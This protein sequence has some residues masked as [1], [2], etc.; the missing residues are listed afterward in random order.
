MKLGLIGLN[1]L[2]AI[3]SSQAFSAALCGGSREE[4]TTSLSCPAGQVISSVTF[5]S[6]GTPGGSCGSYTL[7]SCNASNSKNVIQAACVGKAS[8]QVRASNGIF[9]DPCS[10]IYK[11][12]LTQV[13]CAAP[14]P[15]TGWTFCANE[16]GVCNFTGTKTV[17]Y[18]ANNIFVTKTLNGPVNCSNEVFGDPVAGATKR[19]ELSNTTVG[20]PAPAPV[21]AP[22]PST[23]WTFC[24][25]EYEVCNFSGARTVRYGAN[26]IFVTKTLNGP[27][28]CSN[29]VFG[30]PVAGATKRCELSNT[31]V[32]TPAPAPAPAPPPSGSVGSTVS[33]PGLTSIPGNT[34]SLPGNIS[35]GATVSLQCGQVYRG[36]LDLNNK[37]NI[38]VNVSGSCGKPTIVPSSGQNGINAVNGDNIRISGIKIQSAVR[39]INI[40][41]AKTIS[42]YN[43][44]I[45]N[46]SD[47][48]IYSSGIVG[49]TVDSS[50]ISNSGTSGIDG[51]SWVVNGVV[52]NSTFTGSGSAGGS[53]V[54]IGIYFGDGMNNRI[55][56]VTVTNSVYHGIVVLHNRD[57]SVT[58]SLVNDT[59]TG[60]DHDCGAIYTGAR[61]QLPLNLRIEG[62]SVSRCGGHGVYL[63]DYAN[64]V[65]VKQNA[66]TQTA[67]GISLHN[68]FNTSMTNNNIF[69]NRE[70]HVCF[71]QDNG[72]MRDNQV[73]NNTM[74]STNGEQTFNLQTGNLRAFGTF[75]YNTYTSSNTNVFGRMWDGSSPGV[76]LSYDG[77]KSYMGQDSHSTMNGSP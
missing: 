53:Y 54:G 77:W 45:L 29:E 16:Y 41:N 73:T 39:G 2:F 8:C 43:T 34:L 76:T 71:G 27:V 4:Q 46:S 31:T 37:S 47:S 63:D 50:T 35:N 48:G 44:D 30:D 6:Y 25:N 66:I 61:D 3:F 12:L 68:A 38:T 59:C 33:P 19:C 72:N 75:D 32:G 56:H 18:G 52:T 60:P 20:T 21:P 36:T 11:R 62:N 7:S 70:T 51:G 13:N 49:M 26:N 24:A 67:C 55:D 28:N 42:I 14:A 17:R 15:S 23:E 69:S 74:R 22:A 10:G 40:N 58:N 65:T 57:T 64:A 1:L 9:G 5:A